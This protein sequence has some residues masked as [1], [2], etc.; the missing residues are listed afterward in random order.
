MCITHMYITDPPWQFLLIAFST[1][2]CIT[3]KLKRRQSLDKNRN[4][5]VSSQKVLTSGTRLYI[6]SGLILLNF[7]I[8]AVIPSI[9][10]IILVHMYT[11]QLPV[12]ARHLIYVIW[13]VN[14]VVDPIIYILLQP[15]IRNWLRMKSVALFSK[16]EISDSRIGSGRAQV[17]LSTETS[18]L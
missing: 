5:T 10:D 14:F 12:F 9:T 8:L 17:N 16:P 11:K 13:E 1:Y 15:Q 18:Y 4:C 6:I 2:I 3:T 7:V